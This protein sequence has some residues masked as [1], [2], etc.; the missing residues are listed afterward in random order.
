[1][2]KKELEKLEKKLAAKPV[3]VWDTLKEA[4]KKEVEKTAGDYKAFLDAAKTEREA[5]REIA[6]RAGKA[7]FKPLSGRERPARVYQA[8][9]GKVAA[10]SVAGRKPLTEGLRLIVSHL[11]APRLDLKPRPL[12]EEVDLVLLKTHYYGGVKKYQWLSRPLALHGCVVKEDGRVLDLVLGEDENDPVLT[13]ADLL[14]HLAR[15]VQADKKVTEA[16]PGEKL[17]LLA[18]SLPLGDEEVKSRFKLAVLDLLDRKWGLVEE[19]F[20]SAEFEAVPAGKA[21]DVGLDRSLIG[22]YGQDDRICAYCS[23]DALTKI[24]DPEYTCL[25]LFVDKEEVGSDG[26]TGAKSR[27]FEDFVSQLMDKAGLA[28]TS[29]ALRQALINTKA[30]SADVNGALDPDFQEVHE[31]MNAAKLGYGPCVTKFTGHGGKYGASEASAELMGWLRGIFRKE[32]I[33]WQPAL[34]GKVDE[35]GGGTVA[36]FLAKYGLEIVDCGPAL[37]AMHAPFEI[38]SKADVYMTGRA[39]QAFYRAG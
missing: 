23:L 15:Q 25:A 39:Y 6:A 38:S 9:R 34:L 8:V 1:M 22:G 29:A 18:G 13:I 17:N 5:V 20:V 24:K 4:E 16:F 21:R 33:V 32:K 36:M 14:P 2:K 31:K 27:F 30:L 37:L 26:A 11:D 12:Y 7:G 35:G 10:V 28:P 3:L 19:D